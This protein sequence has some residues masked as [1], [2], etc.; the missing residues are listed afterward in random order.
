MGLGVFP[1]NALKFCFFGTC[2]HKSTGARSIIPKE[3]E[4]DV[5]IEKAGRKLEEHEPDASLH[6]VSEYA[7]GIIT[8]SI[9]LVCPFV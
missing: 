8:S 1:L 5:G 2:V 6:M 4:G 3:V 9:I 7:E